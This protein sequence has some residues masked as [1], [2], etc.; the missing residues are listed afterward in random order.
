MRSVTCRLRIHFIDCLDLK[1]TRSK[2]VNNIKMFIFV[3]VYVCF[4]RERERGRE[5]LTSIAITD[6]ATW[7]V[8]NLLE[9][10]PICL[11]GFRVSDHCT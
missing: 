5:Y 6:S 11:R 9:V 8:T 4:E 7:L 1:N 10:P 3:F 2:G